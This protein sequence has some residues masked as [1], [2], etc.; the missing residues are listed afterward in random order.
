M[1]ATPNTGQSF[2]SLILAGG[3]LGD[4]YYDTK[5]TSTD[6]LYDLHYVVT[7]LRSLSTYDYADVNRDGKITSTDALYILHFVVGNVNEYYQAV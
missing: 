1:T 4:V 3:K 6:S 7:N 2:V 5:V